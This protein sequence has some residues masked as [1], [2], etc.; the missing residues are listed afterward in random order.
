MFGRPSLRTRVRALEKEQQ[1]TRQSITNL[2][3]TVADVRRDYD[4][5]FAIINQSASDTQAQIND[6]V[7]KA[8][9]AQQA[10]DDAAFQQATSELKDI[11][12]SHVQTVTNNTIT[13]TWHL[14]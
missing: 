1:V 3:S 14:G 2:E 7:S 4:G 6:A 5:K 11:M 12:A 13:T 10:D 9:A 8:I